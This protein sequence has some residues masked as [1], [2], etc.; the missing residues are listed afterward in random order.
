MDHV[1]KGENVKT[2]PF[3]SDEDDL[4]DDDEVKSTISLTKNAEETPTTAALI[5]LPQEK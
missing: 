3:D 2:D 5:H 1:L 4:T